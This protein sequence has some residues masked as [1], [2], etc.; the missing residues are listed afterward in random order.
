MIQM[1]FMLP[2]LGKCTG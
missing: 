2:C 1:Y